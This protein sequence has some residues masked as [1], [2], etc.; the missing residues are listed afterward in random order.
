MA[1]LNKA[2]LSRRAPQALRKE[3]NTMA[4]SFCFVSPSASEWTGKQPKPWWAIQALKGYTV[5]APANAHSMIT[6][7]KSALPGPL[8]PRCVSHKLNKMNPTGNMPTKT[9]F[10]EMTSVINL[11]ATAAQYGLPSRNVTSGAWK[12]S[13]PTIR[14]RP[15]KRAAIDIRL[16]SLKDR[17]R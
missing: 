4:F 2:K 3:G 10:R 1:P 13:N 17:M 6:P 11:R 12:I 7:Q 9:K 8:N 15:Y 14:G 16:D 5:I